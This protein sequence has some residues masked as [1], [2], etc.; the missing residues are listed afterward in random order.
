MRTPLT[1]LR[2]L[3]HEALDIANASLGERDVIERGLATIGKLYGV[4][5]SQI[6][7]CEEAGKAVLTLTTQ[8][9]EVL[10]LAEAVAQGVNNFNRRTAKKQA[11]GENGTWPPPPA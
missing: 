7:V 6:S 8:D 10:S 2:S 3:L 11:A 5:A 1:T 4:P 9:G